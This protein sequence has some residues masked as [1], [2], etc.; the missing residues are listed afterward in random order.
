MSRQAITKEIAAPVPAVFAVLSNAEQFAAALPHVVRT[1]FVSEQRSG[2]G[3]VFRE[4]RSLRGREM[5]FELQ[6]TEYETDRKV[7]MVTESHGTVWDTLFEVEPDGE[8]TRLIVSSDA[9]SER[10]LPKIRNWLF[11]GMMAKAV[12]ND[13]DLLKAYVERR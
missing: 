13:L 11:R 5:T 8:H 1:E 3:T 6:V 2:L 7:R 4:T 10:L 12:A 9:I